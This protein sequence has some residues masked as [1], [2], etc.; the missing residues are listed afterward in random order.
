MNNDISFESYDPRRP[1][2]I[3]VVAIILGTLTSTLIN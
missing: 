1:F 3:L 2:L